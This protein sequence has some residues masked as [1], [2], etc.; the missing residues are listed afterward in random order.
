MSLTFR[1][2]LVFL[3]LVLSWSAMA[4]PPYLD[5]TEGEIDGKVAVA[6]LAREPDD[7]SGY[8]PPDGYEA[9][10]VPSTDLDRELV[11]PAGEWF[12]PP[13]GRYRF[14]VE[15]NWSMS[16]GSAIIQ[17]GGS[18]FRSRGMVSVEAVHPAGLIALDP[19]VEADAETALRLLHVESHN[20]GKFPQREISRRA[21]G[22]ERWEGVLMPEGRVVAGLFDNARDEYV[23]L[24]QP[25]EVKARQKVTVVPRP[26][27]AGTSHVVVAL[28]R[29][30]PVSSYEEYDVQ[31][32]LS[33]GEKKVAASVTI[34]TADRVYAVWYDVQGRYGKLTVEA[35]TVFLE[36][37]ELPLRPGKVERLGSR[38]SPLPALDV[39][40][41]LPE[42][43]RKL[44]A[45]LALRSVSQRTARVSREL[46]P[47]KDELRFP[48]LPLDR[49]EV[50]LQIGPWRF[51]ET[52]DLRSGQSQ[53]I[54]ISPQP[55]HV[56][57]TV[58]RGDDHHPGT[59]RFYAGGGREHEVVTDEDGEFQ[60]TLFRPV[61]LVRIQLEGFEGPPFTEVFDPPIRF[62][63]E[64]DFHVPATDFEVR[65]VDA[66]TG[67]GI[68]QAQI[69]AR[70]ETPDGKTFQQSATTDVEGVA[71]LQPLRPGRLLVVAEAKGYLP[72][73]EPRVE[74]VHEGDQGARFT[75][76]LEPVGETTPLLLR[77]ADGR[78]ASGAELLA[79]P[80]LREPTY[81]W[82]GESGP[83]GRVDVPHRAEGTYLLVRHPE[84]GF[85]AS[86]W[87]G[88]TDDLLDWTLPR[89]RTLA[90]EVVDNQDEPVPWAGLTLWVEDL[91][92]EGAGLAWLTRTR[93]AADHN[94]VW[95]G[96]NLPVKAQALLAWRLS[97]RE[98]AMMGALDAHA[99]SIPRQ[100]DGPFQVEAAP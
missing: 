14:W 30:T 45:H 55:I 18:P 13:I 33:I 67:Q 36:P 54:R 56:H 90:V 87:T 92:L 66:Q 91:R 79:V 64:V 21:F 69:G 83:D 25:I 73:E 50:E 5:A 46:Q 89:G 81:V 85:R 20:R 94:G 1:W 22:A 49:Y 60:A 3:W 11:Y 31:P 4:Q 82:S 78:P 93:G 88:T 28:E 9:H 19:E 15:G 74:V 23:A 32:F 27:A 84:A 65:V 96:R 95:L 47:D 48:T 98:Q 41:D 8:L 99:A 75:V 7:P 24:S 70:N 57:G 39:K 34:P 80:A 77:L 58:Y 63:R 37:L 44:E 97:A 62:H 10:L 43:L 86:Q 100:A 29:P 42:E 68:A 16:P 61:L 72:L 76:S 40:L 35:D 71:D 12:Q 38:L 53:Q 26:P 51:V 52:A 6:F 59:V 17:Y 2:S